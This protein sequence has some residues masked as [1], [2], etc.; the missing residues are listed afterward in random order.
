MK[1]LK[2]IYIKHSPFFIPAA[3]APS[4]PAVTEPTPAPVAPPK[5]NSRLL[6]QTEAGR[7]SGNAARQ[8][9]AS[10]RSPEVIKQSPDS[11]A[12]SPPPPARKVHR[13]IQKT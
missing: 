5:R 8:G 13:K 6:T 2:Y 4:K 11:E 12:V 1:L 3:N 7:A 10:G 9:P